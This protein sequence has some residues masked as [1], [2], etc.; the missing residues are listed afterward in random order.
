MVRNECGSATV[1]NVVATASASFNAA[2]FGRGRFGTN[3]VQLSN[4]VPA[5]GVGGKTFKK[6]Y[7][8]ICRLSC[9]VNKED[10]AQRYAMLTLHSYAYMPLELN[11]TCLMS[12]IKLKISHKNSHAMSRS[13]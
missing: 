3:P 10:F 2:G 7:N 4:E 1:S 8:G 5:W 11:L 9:D 13:V 12:A 6:G